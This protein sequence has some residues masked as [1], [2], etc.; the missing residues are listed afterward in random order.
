MKW[1]GKS[2]GAPVCDP[3]KHAPTPT[4]ACAYCERAIIAGDQGVILPFHGNPGDP[5]ELPY[6]HGCL[7]QS[8]GLGGPFVHI[9][10]AGFPICGFSDKVPAEWPAGHKWVGVEDRDQATCPSCRVMRKCPA[11]NRYALHLWDNNR[12]CEHCTS[13]DE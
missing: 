9:L 4:V 12:G 3:A 6:H 13:E 2:W 7:M 1:F 10:I 8:L 5:P 11:C